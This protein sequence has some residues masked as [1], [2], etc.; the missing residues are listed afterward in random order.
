MGKAIR[1]NVRARWLPNW[2][3]GKKRVS[4]WIRA[5]HADGQLN[6]DDTAMA[7]SQLQALLKVFA[8][9]PQ[10]TM[11]QPPLSPAKQD[12]VI[13]SAVDLFLAR[14]AIQSADRAL[15]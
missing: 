15:G 12:Y 11:G 13:S 6:A 1:P 4:V 2:A 9:W 5:A 10:I 7:A 8:F 3:S 14:Y